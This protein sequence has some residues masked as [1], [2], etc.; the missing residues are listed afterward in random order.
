MYV[1]MLPV[2]ELLGGPS[3]A[4]MTGAAEP[5]EAGASPAASSPKITV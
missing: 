5:E 1:V 3:S 2:S 4:A